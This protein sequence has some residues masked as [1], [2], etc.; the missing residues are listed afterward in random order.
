MRQ[1]RKRMS[2]IIGFGIAECKKSESRIPFQIGNSSPVCRTTLIDMESQFILAR[3]D[4]SFFS[5]ANI[6][7]HFGIQYGEQRVIFDAKGEVVDTI[8]S[9]WRR[10]KSWSV[11]YK[12]QR[13]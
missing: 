6:R 2:Y 13:G 4:A 7:M 5:K 12:K 3:Q 8:Y 10:H 9:F 1:M 11:D